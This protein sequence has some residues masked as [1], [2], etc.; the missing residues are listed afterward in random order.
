M[1]Y[2]RYDS[3]FKYFRAFSIV[4]LYRHHQPRLLCDLLAHSQSSYWN[5]WTNLQFLRFL[6]II[7][8][9][10]PCYAIT[11]TT[12]FAITM[13]HSNTWLSVTGI[14][15]MISFL[16]WHVVCIPFSTNI[17]YLSFI[18]HYSVIKI[19]IWHV[20]IHVCV[21]VSYNCNVDFVHALQVFLTQIAQKINWFSKIPPGVVR[22]I[23]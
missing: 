8:N 18:T 16:L 17:W 1:C 20:N 4:L 23:L 2:I 3:I 7:S 12:L 9:F 13:Q 6:F 5:F 19:Y 11:L 15:S 22:F 10:K 21:S 14:F